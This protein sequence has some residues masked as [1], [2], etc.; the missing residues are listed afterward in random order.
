[1]TQ[2]VNPPASAPVPTQKRRNTLGLV[3]MIA[4]IAGFIFAC[5]P[6]ALVVGWL[7]L[8]ISFI[9][10]LVALFRKGES[11]WQAI[12]AIIV[13]VVGTV[14]GAVVFFVL[15][16]GAVNDA[17]GG[18]EAT[19]STSSGSG[20]RSGTGADV[21]TGVGTRTNPAPLGSE[22]T[23]EEWKV[24]V[25]SVTFDATAAVLAADPLNDEPGDGREFILVNYS[26]T[27]L[28]DDANGQSP[29]IHVDV[30]YVSPDGT[31]VGTYDTP[32][33][34]PDAIASMTTLYNGG[35]VTG[36]TAFAVDSATAKDGVI[37]VRPG[38]LADKVFVALQ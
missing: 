8:P 6:G 32:V 28:G 4:A 3:A 11:H 19:V 2:P 27:Y 15:M 25:N 12:T 7:L 33:V 31:T 24:V 21:S 16:A 10:G 9:L 20:G 14:V 35:S 38:I 30:A 1:M 13:A 5:M 37:A 23:G 36:N 22:I 34:A 26:V 17:L 29:A 18:S